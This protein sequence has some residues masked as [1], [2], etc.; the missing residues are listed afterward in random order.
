MPCRL[1][2]G[3]IWKRFAMPTYESLL[4]DFSKGIGE[5]NIQR[6]NFRCRLVGIPAS[7]SG[8]PRDRLPGLKYPVF[9]NS[10]KELPAFTQKD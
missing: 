7:Y 6:S 3:T 8:A 10:F 9:L 2:I 4:S 5:G 1:D